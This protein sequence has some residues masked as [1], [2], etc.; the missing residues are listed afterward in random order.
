MLFLVYNSIEDKKRGKNMEGM[1]IVSFTY[2][3]DVQND[4]NGRAII[5]APMQLMTPKFLP[6]DYS[7]NVSFGIFDVKKMV[8]IWRQVFLIQKEIRL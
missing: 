8:L 1:K 3:E 6:T 7:F 2:C 5:I 4:S